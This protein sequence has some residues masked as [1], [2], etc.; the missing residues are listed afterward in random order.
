[1]STFGTDFLVPLGLMMIPAAV[2]GSVA[3][4]RVLRARRRARRRVVEKPNSHYT[5]PIVRDVET[6]HRWHGVRLD[7]IHEINRE[8][9]VRLLARVEAIGVDSLRANE[10]VFLDNMA[11]I[12]GTRTP[13]EEGRDK[14]GPTVP[15]LRPHPA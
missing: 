5:S 14:G 12:S 4:M 13:V 2:L 6:R 15:E 7:R 1:M 11:E 9:V 10:R 3:L 8:E